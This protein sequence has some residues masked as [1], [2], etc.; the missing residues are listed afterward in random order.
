[1]LHRN[2]GTDG[3]IGGRIHR[4][5]NSFSSYLPALRPIIAMAL[6]LG[7]PMTGAGAQEKPNDADLASIIEQLSAPH[8][9]GSRVDIVNVDPAKS[10]SCRMNAAAMKVSRGTD[11]K[12]FPVLID[13]H[14]D[15]SGVRQMFAKLGRLSVDADGAGRAYHADD[16]FGDC[17]PSSDRPPRRI[18]ALDIFSDAGMRL[19]LGAT[20]LRRADPKSQAADAPAFL[21]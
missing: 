20:R 8:H 12:S 18:C 6:L 16:P 14:G 4:R 15:A 17:S 9:D 3:K 5:S 10:P 2:P 1:M 11:S 13:N 19:F 21:P 7:W